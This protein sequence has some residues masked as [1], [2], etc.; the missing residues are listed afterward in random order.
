MVES[1]FDQVVNKHL[2]QVREIINSHDLRIKSEISSRKEENQIMLK[3]MQEHD[4]LKWELKALKM[5]I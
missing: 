5:Q 1:I 2:T 4:N 3:K